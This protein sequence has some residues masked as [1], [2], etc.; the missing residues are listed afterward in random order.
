VT[1][2]SVTAPS[3]QVLAGQTLQLTANVNADPGLTDVSWATSNATVATVTATGL[4]SAI[5]R[6]T[7]TV[8][9]TSRA[10]ASKAGSLTLT[11]IGVASVAVV[12][13]RDSLRVTWA[14]QVSVAVVADP[15]ISTTV[16][17]VSRNTA[18]ATVTPLTATTANVTAGTTLGTTYIV[19]TSRAD[20]TKQDSVAIRVA[21]VCEVPVPISIGGAAFNGSIAPATSCLGTY[22]HVGFTL[23]AT[24][25]FSVTM[26]APFVYEMRRVVTSRFQSWVHTTSG[27][28]DTRFVIAA[29]G[30][31]TSRLTASSSGS[32]GSVSITLTPWNFASCPGDVVVT[33]GIITGAIPITAVCPTYAPVQTSGGTFYAL[34]ALILPSILSGESV[35]ITATGSGFDPRVDLYTQ[36]PPGGNVFA[37]NAVAPAGTSSV[38]L[39]YTNTGTSSQFL[40]VYFTTRLAAQTGT[41]TFQISGPP[42]GSSVVDPLAPRGP[43]SAR[44]DRPR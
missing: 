38:S 9:A 30:A 13:K 26:T 36:V 6:G 35:S 42:A 23:G 7:V 18:I 14:R 15:T 3:T 4:V 41:L 8:T 11:V 43:A 22:E 24:T 1:S 33:T 17:W 2:V 39:N 5:A 32:S 25:A 31:Y 16:D 19:A 20:G 34:R 28:T 12:P 27:G 40:S 37:T 21:G 44:G 29:P 10:D